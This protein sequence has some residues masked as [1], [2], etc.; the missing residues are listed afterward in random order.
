M[1]CTEPWGCVTVVRMYDSHLRGVKCMR[2][3]C[4]LMERCAGHVR[5]EKGYGEVRGFSM[6]RGHLTVIG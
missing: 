3:V 2:K 5:C 4:Q 1:R 6:L